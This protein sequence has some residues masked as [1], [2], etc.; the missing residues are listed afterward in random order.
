MIEHANAILRCPISGS[1]LRPLT[2]AELAD[3][4]ARRADGVAALST[5]YVS[6]DGRYA[7]PVVDG[8]GRLMPDAAI[9]LSGGS[10][11]STLRAE[12]EAVQAFY[13]TKGWQKDD[14]GV[15]VDT[16]LFLD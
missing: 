1:A 13:D 5:G 10:A 15:F 14:D 6:E 2:E 7:Y 8:I 11:E 9:S 12:K 16:A 3:V 4:N